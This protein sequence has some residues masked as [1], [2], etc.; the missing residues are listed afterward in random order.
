MQPPRDPATG[1]PLPL[2]GR[3]AICGRDLWSDGLAPSRDGDA[4]I[5]GDCDQAR[6]F[7]AEMELGLDD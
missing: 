7:E 3:C 5:C 4:W 2:T 1:E 6:S